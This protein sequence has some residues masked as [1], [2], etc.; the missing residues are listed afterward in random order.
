M[1]YPYSQPSANRT[2][3]ALVTKIRTVPS[4]IVIFGVMLFL[5]INGGYYWGGR[6]DSQTAMVYVLMFSFA[7]CVTFA[8]GY[9]KLWL[10]NMTFSDAL[11]SFWVGFLIGVAVCLVAN[12]YL[13]GG[14]LAGQVDVSTIYP[15][16]FLTVF[17]VAFTEE[18]IFRGVLKEA[19]K[20]WRLG[21]FPLALIIPSALF[22]MFHESAYNGQTYPLFIAFVLGIVL[23]LVTEIRIGRDSSGKPKKLGVPGSAGF[24]TAFN[25]MVLGIIPFLLGVH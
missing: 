14:A 12:A 5:L 23:Y 10:M 6:W 25:L 22:S 15:E 8:A 4:V 11:A 2:L 18:T 7:V 17:F 13:F 9:R 16:I 20:G 3:S 21:P 19:F 1:S 24:H